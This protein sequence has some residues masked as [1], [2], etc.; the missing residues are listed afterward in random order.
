MIFASAWT[1]CLYGE[2]TFT[3]ILFHL[4]FLIAGVDLTFVFSFIGHVIIPSVV[5]SVLFCFPPLSRKL[6]NWCSK[7]FQA[8]SKLKVFLIIVALFHTLWILK[9]YPQNPFDRFLYSL[10]FSEHSTIFKS[11]AKSVV[12]PSALLGIVIFGAPLW[13]FLARKSPKFAR[14]MQYIDSTH[15]TNIQTLIISSTSK[16]YH[17]IS[18]FCARTLYAPF[19]ELLPNLST[20]GVANTNFSSTQ[21]FG[22]ITQVVGTGWTIAGLTSYLCAIP[23][24]LPIKGNSFAHAYFLDSA[25]CVGDILHSLGYTQLAIQGASIKF[26]GKNQFYN[27][28]HISLHGE[29]YFTSQYFASRNIDPQHCAEFKE[30]VAF[31]NVVLCADKNVSEFISWAKSQD[32]YKDTSIIVLGDH[33]SMKQDYFPQGTKRA[34]F[35]TF[36]NPSFSITPESSLTKNRLV[37][38]FDISA[39]ILDSIGA[40]LWAWTQS[41]I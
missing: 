21:S 30:N 25:T 33:L 10:G 2:V 4:Q 1:S 12:L 23:L 18:A 32:F 15:Y 14:L 40:C 5:I 7:H 38:H 41:T 26:A 27:S 13:R 34:I 20:L 28:H 16:L 11:F 29:E 6:I 19:G 9:T 22:R 31:N 3:Q 36:I 24:K 37:S 8:S 35:N 39:L 17:K